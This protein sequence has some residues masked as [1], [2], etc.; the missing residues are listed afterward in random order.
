MTRTSSFTSTINR[1]WLLLTRN[2]GFSKTPREKHSRTRRG[3][4]GV[5]G[6]LWARLMTFQVEHLE[7]KAHDSPVLWSHRCVEPREALPRSRITNNHL[8]EPDAQVAA[9]SHT[10]CPPFP[11]EPT[12]CSRLAE[13]GQRLA[14]LQGAWH[15]VRCR[16]LSCHVR[17]YRR[18]SGP[19]PPL[20]GP[21]YL[22]PGFGCPHPTDFSPSMF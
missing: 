21:S 9:I 7:D 3:P 6:G 5:L 2:H 14:T 20:S 16:V 18:D 8:A 11:S 12:P 22:V 4:R 10:S 13:P 1:R 19:L 15:A 17:I